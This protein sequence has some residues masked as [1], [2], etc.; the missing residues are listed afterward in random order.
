MDRLADDLLRPELGVVDRPGDAEMLHL[1]V[2]EGLVD[3]VDRA[4]RHADLVQALDPIGV[5]VLADDLVQMRDQRRAVLGAGHD[6]GEIGVVGRS[7]LPATSQKR[8]H[9]LSPEA[10]MLM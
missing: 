2:G 7:L 3:R 8:R 5:R 9:R 6:R 1:R 4:A 10:A